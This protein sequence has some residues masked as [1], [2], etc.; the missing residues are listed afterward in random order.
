MTQNEREPRL[1][2]TGQGFPPSCIRRRSLCFMS[3][4]Q[5]QREEVAARRE[6]ILRLRASGTSVRRIAVSWA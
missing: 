6:R 2:D 1:G 5:T 3:A 4:S